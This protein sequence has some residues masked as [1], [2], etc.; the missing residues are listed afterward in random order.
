VI[1]VNSIGRLFAVSGLLL[2]CLT[3]L[4]WLFH[5]EMERPAARLDSAVRQSERVLEA[6]ASSVSSDMRDGLQVYL[7]IEDF[8]RPAEIR[9]LEFWFASAGAFLGLDIVGSLGIAQ[10]SRET[11]ASTREP[12]VSAADSTRR[13]IASLTDDCKSLAILREH[14]KR[15][16]VACRESGLRCALYLACF[17]H[18]G[19]PDS[20]LQRSRDRAYLDDVVASY[21]KIAGSPRPTAR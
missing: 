11:Y 16:H 13:W 3:C 9:R 8:F 17:W 6:C 1:L 10:I 14:A 5:F 21:S 18:T 15:H 20:C 12:E 4:G 19:R 2:V 7:A